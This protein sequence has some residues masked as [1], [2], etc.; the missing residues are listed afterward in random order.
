MA[1][2]HLKPDP[3]HI[4]HEVVGLLALGIVVMAVVTGAVWVAFGGAAAIIVLAIIGLWG[5]ARLSRRARR[6][7]VDEALHPRK[8]EKRIDPHDRAIS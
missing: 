3:D 7:R 6:E 8:K 4:P 2:T 5:I 1:T